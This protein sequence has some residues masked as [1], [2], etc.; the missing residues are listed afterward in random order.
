MTFNGLFCF[1][2]IKCDSV[3]ALFYISCS[4]YLTYISLFSFFNFFVNKKTSIVLRI[5]LYNLFCVFSISFI[6]CPIFTVPFAL[7]LFCFMVYNAR[8]TDICVLSFYCT[9][10]LLSKY[11]IYY[12]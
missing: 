3:I 8:F 2:V 5:C 1:S 6:T 10:V 11:F 7:F 12:Y 4:F 9:H